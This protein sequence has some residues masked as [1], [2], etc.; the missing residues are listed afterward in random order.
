[1]EEIF[2]YFNLTMIQ[3]DQSSKISQ[4]VLK[5]QS[6]YFSL[7]IF[8]QIFLVATISQGIMNLWTFLIPPTFPNLTYT[9]WYALFTFLAYLLAIQLGLQILFHSVVKHY[10]DTEIRLSIIPTA[11][12]FIAGMVYTQVFKRH[13][14][15]LTTL[16]DLSQHTLAL[17]K[18]VNPQIERVFPIPTMNF[19]FEMSFLILVCLQ[20]MLYIVPGLRRGLTLVKMTLGKNFERVKDPLMMFSLW[21]EYI[22]SLF[23]VLLY[24]P[25][26]LE[27][28]KGGFASMYYETKVLSLPTTASLFLTAS[29]EGACTLGQATAPT[30]HNVTVTMPLYAN[31][32]LSISW[33]GFLFTTPM[34]MVVTVQILLVL[35]WCVCK[36]ANSALH[37]QSYLDYSIE[38]VSLM[39]MNNSPA[40]AQLAKAQQQAEQAQ[41]GGGEGKKKTEEEEVE[42][43]EQERQRVQL[44][45]ILTYTIEVSTLTRA[46]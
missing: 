14:L 17:L 19:F 39:I 27:K 20:G 1:M 26:I 22:L 31:H 36:Y 45:Q 38:T 3:I 41:E 21:L 40:A 42:E 8:L 10:Y 23:L 28:M 24:H 15:P 32:P 12:I 2:T 9:L 46:H 35:L 43:R 37:W 4:Q 7:N 11:L 29:S 16:S 13:L 44:Q 25:I 34:D 6:Y 18:F 30:L 33:Y 5:L